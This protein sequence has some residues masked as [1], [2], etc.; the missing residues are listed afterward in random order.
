VLQALDLVRQEEVLASPDDHLI[1]LAQPI[2][3]RVDPA[4]D[5]GVHLVDAAVAPV[6][7][8]AHRVDP[9]AHPNHAELRPP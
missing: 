4:D 6:D 1:A 9:P 3:R 2:I 5:L 8:P 7:A